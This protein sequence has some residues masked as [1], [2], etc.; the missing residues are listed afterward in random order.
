MRFSSPVPATAAFS[1]DASLLLRGFFSAPSI[2][3]TVLC[4]LGRGSGAMAELPPL[5][6]PLP[7]R[8]DRCVADDARWIDWSLGVRPWVGCC[9]GAKTRAR[10]SAPLLCWS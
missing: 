4:R 5:P 3:L 9:G 2:V 7:A 10:V 1:A 6:L 8:L